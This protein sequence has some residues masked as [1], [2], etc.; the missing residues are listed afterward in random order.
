MGV[1]NFFLKSPECAAI[2]PATAINYPIDQVQACLNTDLTTLNTY[3]AKL[4]YQLARRTQVT[5]F[6]N[7]AEKVRNARDASDLRPIETTYRQKSVTDKALGSSLWKTGTPKTY[8]LSVRQSFNDRFMMEFQNASNANNISAIVA[9][10]VFRF[11]ARL[12]W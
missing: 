7:M 5:L 3:N 8:K 1:N 11:G 4:N 2:T 9:P 12:T 6:F 10:R